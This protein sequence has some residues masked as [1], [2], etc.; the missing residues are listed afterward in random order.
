MPFHFNNCLLRNLLKILKTPSRCIYSTSTTYST[1]CR[2][3]YRCQEKQFYYKIRRPCAYIYMLSSYC[4]VTL[5][6]YNE[7]KSWSSSPNR[8]EFNKFFTMI[9]NR[10]NSDIVVCLFQVAP[11]NNPTAHTVISI[12]FTQITLLSVSDKSYLRISNQFRNVRLV[13]FRVFKQSFT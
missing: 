1:I 6:S 11:S 9:T 2:L 5:F 3:L 12:S 10:E 8:I 13:D 4:N 7:N